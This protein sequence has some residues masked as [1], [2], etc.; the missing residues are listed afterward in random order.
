M[1]EIG[2]IAIV[3]LVGICYFWPSY[4]DSPSA[5]LQA[6]WDADDKWFRWCEWSKAHEQVFG[7]RLPIRYGDFE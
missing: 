7:T 3:A 2:M 1:I 5:Q 4:C 6:R